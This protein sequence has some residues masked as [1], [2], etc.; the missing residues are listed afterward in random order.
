MKSL[1][2]R[3]EKIIGS[4]RGQLRLGDAPGVVLIIM[5]VFMVMAVSAFVSQE[6]GDA[7]PTTTKTIYNE[8][9]SSVDNSTGT[10]V[11]SSGCHFADFTVIRVSNSTDGVLIDVGNYT[12]FPEGIVKATADSSFTDF[13]WNVTYSFSSSDT[14]AC[15]VTV[16]LNKEL[17]DNTSI[18]GI[19]LTISLIGIVLTTLIGLFLVFTE[20]G[21][22]V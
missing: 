16:D 19:V 9:I 13:D 11:A 1:A 4:K 12:T 3:V 8:T 5:F 7:L 20:R 2:K 10:R 6:F 14:V 18:A 17:A 15:N 22:R 21:P